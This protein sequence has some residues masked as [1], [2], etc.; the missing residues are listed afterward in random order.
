TEM[1]EELERQKLI[2]EHE[3]I[4]KNE[5]NNRNTTAPEPKGTF[6]DSV[7]FIFASALAVSTVLVAIQIMPAV[8]DAEGARI[9]VYTFGIFGYVALK[10]A[11]TAARAF[12]NV[13]KNHPDNAGKPRKRLPIKLSEV[14]YR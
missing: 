2:R 14:D 8:I 10:L 12:T 5:T 1:E 3:L 13:I 11:I 4:I 6:G 7:K 9:G